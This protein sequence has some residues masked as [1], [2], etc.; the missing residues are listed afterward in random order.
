MPYDQDFDLGSLVESDRVHKA[1]YADEQVY[2]QE[3]ENI[4]YKSWIYIGHESQVPNAGDY[5][6]TWIGKE[7]MILCRADDGGVHVL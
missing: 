4:F 6:T 1:C 2:E 3:L 5:W 7:R